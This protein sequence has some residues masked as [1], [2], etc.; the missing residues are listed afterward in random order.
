MMYTSTVHA[1]NDD[2]NVYYHYRD[3][4]STDVLDG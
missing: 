3:E 4:L 1:I 2:D